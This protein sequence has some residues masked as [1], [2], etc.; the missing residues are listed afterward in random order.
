MKKENPLNIAC[1]KTEKQI[2]TAYF[3]HKMPELLS[4]I[5]EDTKVGGKE[6]GLLTD[7][8]ST[9][10]DENEKI[11]RQVGEVCEDIVD[12][13][14]EPPSIEE[15][16]IGLDD[17]DWREQ[18]DRVI[19]GVNNMIRQGGNLKDKEG[20]RKTLS[21]NFWLDGANKIL[22]GEELIDK[23]YIYK[24]QLYKKMLTK[25]ILDKGVSRKEAEEWSN[26]TKEFR[27][28]KM[29]SLL[30]DRCTEFIQMA[31]KQDTKLNPRY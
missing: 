13:T 10:K 30:K 29:I 21:S 23:D 4:S 14:I 31:K 6:L 27:D 9:L 25:F 3:K 5:Q 22:A 8:L 20:N 28:Y 16:A 19:S 1:G 17:K 24:K 7:F 18:A 15:L 11:F 2:R 12:S 26:L